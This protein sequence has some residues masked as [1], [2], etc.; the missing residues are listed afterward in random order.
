MNETGIGK[1][2][3]EWDMDL[4]VGAMNK[5]LERIQG[6]SHEERYERVK[7]YIEKKFNVEKVVDAIVGEAGC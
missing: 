2:V 5:F 1:A 4:C 7:A 3:H 6:E